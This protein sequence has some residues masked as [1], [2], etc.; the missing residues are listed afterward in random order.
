[1]STAAVAH[2]SAGA[3]LASK[4]KL[5]IAGRSIQNGA[6]NSH[7]S[8]TDA[9]ATRNK[10]STRSDETANDNNNQQ[11]SNT[12]ENQR[13]ANGLP[14]TAELEE[15]SAFAVGLADTTVNGGADLLINTMQPAEPHTYIPVHVP[16]HLLETSECIVIFVEL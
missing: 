13:L 2:L 14:K 12:R 16:D 7:L 11:T 10:S 1:M 3:S 5:P 4:H 8:S 9:V 15:V 6:K